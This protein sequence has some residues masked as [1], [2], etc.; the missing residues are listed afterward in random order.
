MST[1]ADYTDRRVDYF[2]FRGVF[3]RQTTSEQLLAQRLVGSSDGGQVVA[4]IEKL[5]QRTL[6][7]LLCK[8]GSRVYSPNEGTTFMIDAARG[9][10][11]TAADVESSF[12][13]ARLAVARQ[14]QAVEREDDPLDERWGSLELLGVVLD[15]DTVSLRMSLVSAA[16]TGYVFLTPIEVSPR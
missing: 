9:A 8:L 16:G 4:G 12:Y 1:L 5:A 14:V 11:R 13:A 2:A 10:W 3:E 15:G 7:I 6:L